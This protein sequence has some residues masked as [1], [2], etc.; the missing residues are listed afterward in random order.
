M[1]RRARTRN[2]S[3]SASTSLVHAATNPPPASAATDELP[4]QPGLVV[5]TWIC[6]ST[7]VTPKAAGRQTCLVSWGR[8]AGEK[9]RLCADFLVERVTQVEEVH[10]GR[11]Y[12][13]HY[14]TRLHFGLGTCKHV[15]RVEVR[16]I[17]GGVDV[18][19]NVPVDKL[20][21]VTEGGATPKP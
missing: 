1:L 19:K 15:D 18:L 2:S 21:T 6:W 17:G 10:S 5:L 12:Q 11:G 8:E 20:L 4:C 7:G 13:S 3:A 9:A 14:G 16:W